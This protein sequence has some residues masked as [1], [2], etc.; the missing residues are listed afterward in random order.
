MADVLGKLMRNQVM[1]EESKPGL[2]LL[3]KKFKELP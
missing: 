1:E 2:A 3:K